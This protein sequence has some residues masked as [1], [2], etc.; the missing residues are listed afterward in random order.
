MIDH[1][2][3]DRAEDVAV[4]SGSNERLL[5]VREAAVLLGLKPSTLYQWAY[6]QRIPTVKLLGRRGA[7]RFR[8]SDIDRLI[9]RSL[10]PAR[11]SKLDDP[12]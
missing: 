2:R 7:L 10:R 8:R 4:K 5:G 1:G 11:T 12:S 9:T 6:L 3:D